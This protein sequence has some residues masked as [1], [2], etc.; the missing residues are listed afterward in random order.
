LFVE[1]LIANVSRSKRVYTLLVV[2]SSWADPVL[3]L[4]GFPTK[5]L[6]TIGPSGKPEGN[7]VHKVHSAVSLKIYLWVIAMQSRNE[8]GSGISFFLSYYLSTS[9]SYSF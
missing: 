9:S 5:P 7:V 2:L 6:K 3:D 8:W 1:N 4:N